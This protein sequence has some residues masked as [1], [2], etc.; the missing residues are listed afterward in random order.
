M[1]DLVSIIIPLYNSAKYISE[2][3]NSC[4]AQTYSNV[5]V[6]V[7]DDGSTDNGYEL[8][9]EIVSSDD[10]V[11]IFHRENSG[12]SSARNF[13]IKKSMGEYVCF[14]DADDCL[15][16]DF[17]EKM[18]DCMVEEK[19]DFCFSS[20]V[21]SDGAPSD[22]FCYKIVTS[23]EAEADLLGT[24]IPVGCWNKMY[25]RQCLATH[26]FDERLFYGE[27]LKFILRVAHDARKIIK[28]NCSSYCY[29]RVNPD[30]AT[31][32]FSLDKMDNG[33]KS[34][35]EIMEIIRGDGGRVV[36]VWRQ[37]HA[38]FCLDA[39][40]GAL[41]SD[42]EK[43]IYRKWRNEFLKDAFVGLTLE[44]GLRSKIRI[45]LGVVSPRLLSAFSKVGKG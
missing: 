2:C 38:L 7:V 35:L 18:V 9:K 27:G 34:L 30:S 45:V 28:C 44:A 37:H 14:V 23:A 15:G 25:S 36:S 24:K 29:R 4:L 10:R 8:I 26:S 40:I 39:M 43:S 3:V 19:A 31:T 1:S 11:R 5:E 32:K 20:N 21:R 17:V 22:E 41:N 33:D 16:V 42:A 6:I 13:G 12:V